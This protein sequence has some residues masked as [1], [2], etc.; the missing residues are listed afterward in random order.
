MRSSTRPAV[1]SLHLVDDAAVGEEH[2]PV[3][4]AGGDRVVGDHDDRLA[5]LVDGLAHERRISAPAL[6]SR[7]PVG[8]SAKMISRPAGQ[9]P[10]HGDPLLLAAGQLR[11]RCCSRSRETD[12]VDHRVEPRLVGLAAGEAPAGG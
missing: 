10:G 1:G 7:L 11:R 5:E 12:G 8:S 3:G 2:D 6:E 9:R 4:V